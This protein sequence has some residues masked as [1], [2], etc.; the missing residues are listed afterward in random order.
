MDQ[1]FVTDY[2]GSGVSATHRK[3]MWVVELSCDCE[4]LAAGR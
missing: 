1:R 2:A 4:D 3:P